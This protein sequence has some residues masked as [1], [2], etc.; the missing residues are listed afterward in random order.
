MAFIHHSN[1]LKGYVTRYQVYH[2]V[3]Y[4]S[5]HRRLALYHSG[6]PVHSRSREPDDNIAP[7]EEPYHCPEPSYYPTDLSG[8]L[9]ICLLGQHSRDHHS[10]PNEDPAKFR[11][12]IEHGR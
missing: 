2:Q 5:P 1:Q 11:L 7:Q 8:D 3:L 9:I 10:K 4:D 12:T 6:M